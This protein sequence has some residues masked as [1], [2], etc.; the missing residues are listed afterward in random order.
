MP[1][2]EST[3]LIDADLLSRRGTGLDFY[4]YRRSLFGGHTGKEMREPNNWRV[5]VGCCLSL[6]TCSPCTVSPT[7]PNIADTG[8]SVCSFEVAEKV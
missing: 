8:A 1:K 2:I 5:G 3:S 4:R 6:R 7:D